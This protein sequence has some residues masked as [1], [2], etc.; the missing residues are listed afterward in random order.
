VGSVFKAYDIRGRYP[1]ELDEPLSRKIGWGLGVHLGGGDV[2]VGRD[3]RH[4]APAVGAAAIDGLVRAGCAVTDIGVCT[5]PMLYFAV[6]ARRARGGLMVTASHNPPQDIGMKLCRQEAIPIGRGSGL[7]AIESSAAGPIVERPGGRLQT[8]DLGADYAGHIRRALRPGRPIRVAVD[9]AGGAVGPVFERIFGPDD[10]W[11][12]EKLCFAP[13]PDFTRH[14]PDPLKDANVADLAEAVRRTGAEVGIAF[15]GDGDRCIFL[16]AAG[17]RIPSDLITILLAQEALGRR[18][19]A[20]I[21]YDLRSSRA[22]PEEIRRAG[23]RPVRERV[24]HAFIKLTMRREQAAVGGELS[25]HFYFQEH[26]YADS[27]LLACARILSILGSGPATLEERVRPY[28]RY[29]ATG[30]VNFQVADKEA[31]MARIAE[32]F[33]AHEQDR[34]D[35]V[36][37]NAADWWFNVRPSNTE[38]RLRL[39]LEASTD[40]RRREILG[41][42]LEILGK[43]L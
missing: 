37:V 13:D 12:F 28:R 15:D 22:V 32:R 24:G 19:G 3:I 9:A 26:A 11:R 6:A 2:V 20:A 7:E 5:T 39:N 1:V 31:A 4:S 29:F 43:P 34:L 35:G 18:P 8:C 25:G 14:E 42:L 30:E 38:P 17:Q 10:P 16:D 21:V 23:G 40:E 36:T 27:G 33:G 41:G